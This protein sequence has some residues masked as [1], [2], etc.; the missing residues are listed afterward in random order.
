MEIC[1]APTLQLK[2]LKKCF[3][4]YTRNVHRDGKCYQKKYICIYRQVFKHNYAKDAH[5]HTLTHIK[6]INNNRSHFYSAVA[7]RQGFTFACRVLALF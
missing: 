6:G 2:A 3:T 5:A 4:K 7:H 1:K